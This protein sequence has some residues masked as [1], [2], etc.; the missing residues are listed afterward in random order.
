MTNSLLTSPFTAPLLPLQEIAEKLELSPDRY[1]AIGAYGAKLKLDLLTDPA[2]PVR[3]RLILVTATT[4]TV[5][6]EGKTVVSIGLA[7]GLERIGQ[8]S[9]VTSREPSL[10]PIFGLKG[11]A[12]GGGLSQVEPSQKINLHFNGDFHAITAAHNLLAAL[13]DA[14]IFHGNELDLDPARSPGRARST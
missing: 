7:Q 3:G 1:D 12:A 14:H 6:G 2:F 8:K 13:V 5:S 10:G 9:I 4:P 11:G